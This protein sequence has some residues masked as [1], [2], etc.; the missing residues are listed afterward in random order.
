[1]RRGALGIMALVLAASC[2]APEATRV[3]ATPTLPASPPASAAATP[4]LP[5]SP[6]PSPPPRPIAAYWGVDLGAGPEEYRLVFAFE[7][8]R[9]YALRLA[10]ADRSTLAQVVISGSGVIDT[11]CV[12]KQL[13]AGTRGVTWSGVRGPQLREFLATFGS[14]TVESAEPGAP[15]V[16]LRDSGC[17]PQASP[18]ANLSDLPGVTRTS[19]GL[20]VFDE[21][22][23]L[24]AA[25]VAVQ[26]AFDGLDAAWALGPYQ[27]A[28]RS[29]VVACPRVPTLI[30][31]DTVHPKRSGQG[32]VGTTPTVAVDQVSASQLWVVVATPE[33][34]AYAF[35]PDPL[36]TRAAEEHVCY[37][38]N[39]AEVTSSIYIRPT[40]ATDPV[41][42]RLALLRGLGLLGPS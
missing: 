5:A 25:R 10:R 35:G 17:R 33:R 15:P 2:S 13:P 22:G 26:A 7:S 36:S 41:A 1:M 6:S 3:A 38:H 32:P 23:D 21:R 4:T 9:P 29:P 8:P 34:I 20:C 31:T 14:L 42:L 27:G 40:T 12:L 16:T 11:S 19:L 37:G 30:A 18:R 28:P 39:C 24:T